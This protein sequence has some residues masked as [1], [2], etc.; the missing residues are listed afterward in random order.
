MVG[1]AMASSWAWEEYYDILPEEEV[2]SLKANLKTSKGFREFL[3]HCADMYGVSTF[4]TSKM[5]LFKKKFEVK[6]EIARPALL[7]IFHESVQKVGWSPWSRN[8]PE[9]IRIT[10]QRLLVSI[11]WMGVFADDPMKQLLLGI[12]TDSTK[13]ASF[14]T[15]TLREYL[16]AADA[17]ETRDVLVRFLTGDMRVF[18]RAET[19]RYAMLT[20]DE[21]DGDELKREAILSSVFVS[22]AREDSRKNFMSV[23]KKLAER[24]K[25][26]T[27][28]SQRLAILQRMNKLPPTNW[29]G[30]SSSLDAMIEPLKTHTTFTNVNT[31]L[32]DLIKRDFRKKE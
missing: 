7:D 2:V 12:A 10:K 13:D 22:L 19:Y 4:S 3:I 18:E 23:D 5:P 21:A 9:D 20:Y 11:D 16:R 31:N 25:E 28:S 14:R 29:Y 17:Q 6:G 24:S 27:E 15:K 8:D 1:S 32:T 30:D 26:Y